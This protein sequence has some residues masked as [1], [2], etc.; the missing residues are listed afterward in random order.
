MTTQR[1]DFYILSQDYESFLYRLVDKI[2]KKRQSLYIHCQD[3]SQA[4]GL[5]EWLWTYRDDGFI[6]HNLMG[7]PLDPPP[8]IQLGWDARQARQK[9]ILNCS[10]HA[11]EEPM[12]RILEIIK[13]EDAAKATGRARYAHYREKK[14]ALKT[15][16]ID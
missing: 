6:P 13:N 10:D 11:I 7:E 1:V 9:L 12:P 14:V 15:H 5:D 16:H 3:Q 8:P 4:E 2:Y